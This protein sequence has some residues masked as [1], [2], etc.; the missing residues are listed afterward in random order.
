MKN[1]K[2]TIR[3]GTVLCFDNQKNQGRIRV[4]GEPQEIPFS[5]DS[6]RVILAGTATPEFGP[7]A[8]KSSVKPQSGA[9]VALIFTATYE[10]EVKPER[11]ILRRVVEATAWNYTLAYKAAER[12][13]S[14]RPVYEVVE[15]RLYNG[16]PV[17]VNQREVLNFGTVRQLQAVYPRGAA[18]DPFAPEV[19]RIGFTTRRRFYRKEA[20]GARIQC[21]D[22]RPLPHDT[23]AEPFKPVNEE[24]V[25]LATS[26]EISSI[27]DT[28]TGT[29]TG[30]DKEL[31]DLVALAG[32]KRNGTRTLQ[33]A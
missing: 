16:T 9:H 1:N 10:S 27:R 8:P 29:S 21:D 3:F 5:F 30:D 25:L 12:E 13:I 24:G 31:F 2:Q 28:D 7:T 18:N 33:P 17:S 20:N 32:G 4:S 14:S 22:P 26:E 6:Q 11:H 15:F 23:V 19:S